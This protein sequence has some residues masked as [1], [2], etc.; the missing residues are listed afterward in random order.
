MEAVVSRK[1]WIGWKPEEQAKL[2]VACAMELWGGQ[3]RRFAETF[4]QVENKLKGESGSAV[5]QLAFT[6]NQDYYYRECFGKR[7]KAW[8]PLEVVGDKARQAYMSVGWLALEMAQFCVVPGWNMAIFAHRDDAARSLLHYIDVMWEGIPEHLRVRSKYWRDDFK[9]ID[10]GGGRTNR[11]DVFSAQSNTVPRSYRYQS[12]HFSEGAHYPEKYWL[13]VSA[14]IS[15]M[16]PTWNIWESTRRGTT[17]PESGNPNQ[18]WVRVEGL[19]TEK[20]PG[21]LLQRFWFH[22]GS[23]RLAAGDTRAVPSCQGDFDLTEEETSLTLRFP[24]DD[25]FHLDRIRWRRT[26][27]QKYVRAHGGNAKRGKGVFLQEN[28]EDDASGWANAD[29]TPFDVELARRYLDRFQDGPPLVEDKVDG[30]GMLRQ[31]YAE[32]AP[33][34]DYGFG[35]D[36]AAGKK[37]GDDTSV[38]GVDALDGNKRLHVLR[39]I[40]K[41][42]AKSVAISAIPVC[43]AYN[44]AYFGIERNGGWGDAALQA[45]REMGYGPRLFAPV[46]E[47]RN[48]F[49]IG[50]AAEA[51]FLTTE[52]SKQRI[53]QALIDDFNAE[54]F[55]TYFPA[56]LHMFL[57]YDAKGGGHTPDE[58]ISLAIANEMAK[59]PRVWTK[60]ERGSEGRDREAWSRPRSYAA[61]AGAV[62]GA[63][64][65]SHVWGYA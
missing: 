43:R 40:G 15:P 27:I 12:V 54:Q 38:S 2:W 6:E 20:D 64:S 53:L 35:M 50:P 10:F 62:A 18:H 23:N 8:E 58:M 55:V 49:D 31:R 13:E 61:P 45:A 44:Q 16:Q 48:A 14:A 60:H 41:V 19:R 5:V 46:N 32:P 11:I 51:G 34:A 63:E 21:I 25:I 56:T 26:E 42:S 47:K 37:N 57:N 22:D 28:L 52:A 29:K 9:E 3:P 17:Y 4:F 24:A 1:E 39:M 7:T 30:T 59:D 33:G 36:A 65:D